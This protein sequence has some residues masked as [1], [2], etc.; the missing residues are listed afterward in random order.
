MF[1]T[2]PDY[3]DKFYCLADKCPATCCAGWQIVI[4]EESLKKYIERK[5]ILG[6][7]LKK[8]IDFYNGIFKQFGDRCAFLNEENLCDI[9][10]E[11]GKDMM[12]ETCRNYPKHIEV[13]DDEKE[14]SLMLSC[15]V[16][17]KIILE[18]KD[19]VRFVTKEDKKNE[20]AEEDDF[21]IFLYSALLESRKVIFSV[22]QNRKEDIYLRMRKALILSYHIQ[23]CIDNNNIFNIENVLENFIHK[24][25]PLSLFDTFETKPNKEKVLELLRLLG[26]LEVMDDRWQKDLNIWEDTIIG[27]SDKDFDKNALSETV[28]E[29]ILVYFVF[30]YCTKAVYDYDFFSKIKFSVISTIVW[31]SICKAEKILI[32]KSGNNQYFKDKVLEIAWRFSRELEHSDINIEKMEELIQGVDL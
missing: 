16:V 24:K 9:H 31:E 28:L 25:Y 15:P 18:N 21:D 27:L 5:D 20:A 11:A 10:I 12:C 23:K 8:S 32:L 17:S 30:A 29:Q 3:Y 6:Q 14:V 2:V 7:R 4:D 19:T 22:I 13:Y 26:K 1:Y